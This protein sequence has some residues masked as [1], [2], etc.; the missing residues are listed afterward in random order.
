MKI[1]VTGGA[2][3]IG[4]HIV[5]EL[6]EAGCEAVIV[7]N[8]SNSDEKSLQGVFEIT[9]K[10]CPFYKTDMRDEKKLKTVFEEHKFDACIHCAGLKSVG[11]SVQKPMEYYDNNIGGT[12]LLLKMMREFS[13]KNMIFSSSATV[14]GSAD[15]MPITESAPK[16]ECTNPYGWTKSFIEQI[17]QD[18]Q[19]AD[20]SWNIVLLRYFNPVGAHSSG[21]IGENPKGIP[22]NLMPYIA[23]VAAGELPFL[24]VFGNDYDTPDG[25]GVRDYIHITDLAKGHIRA[26]DLLRRQCGMKVYNL[27]TGRGYSVLEV[28]RAFE[29]V[30]RVKVPFQIKARRPGDVAICFADP[31]K[32]EKEMGWKAALTLEDMCRDLWNWQQKNS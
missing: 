5:V 8:L 2:G 6:L 24:N 31:S 9:G 17:L 32:A 26:L 21:I 20:Q 15:V 29:K 23:K 16:K 22:N 4:S 18:V 28:V 19:R 27:G 25:T 30:C 7:D 10:K 1:L 13:C 14:Y 12:I 3:Y 11:E